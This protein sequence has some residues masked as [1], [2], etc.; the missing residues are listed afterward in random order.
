MNL[1]LHGFGAFGHATGLVLG[2]LLGMAFGFV[3]ERAGFGRAAN[4]A[5]QF[6]GHDNRVFKVMFTGI[7]TTA[8]LLG[9]LSGT[10]AVDLAMLTVPETFLGPQIVGGLLLGA[11]FI[12]AGYCPGTGVVAASSGNVDGLLTY[13]GVMVGSLL[14][15]LAWPWVEGFYGSGA[16]GAVRLDQLVGL[17]FSVVALGVAAMAIGCFVAVERLEVWMAVR[18]EKP[19]PDVAPRLRNGAFAGL[20]GV[21]VFA[22]APVVFA[23]AASPAPAPPRELGWI[24]VP[25]LAAGLV[26]DPSAYWIVDARPPAECA[27][28][29]IP[30]AMCVPA[31]DPTAAFVAALPT[32]RTLVVYDSGICAAPPEGVATWPGDVRKLGGGYTAWKAVVLTPP[33]L[34]EAPS[35]VQVR[36]YRVR[37]ALH[38]RFTG[39]AA[40]AATITVAPP[41]RAAAAPKKGGGC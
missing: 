16:M 41:R 27:G 9:L 1:P 15:G 17:P 3:L 29:R 34:L 33:A 28:D 21:G 40:P 39:V 30:G 38:G 2:V 18:R 8:V 13:V 32:T 5:A 10:G 14:F 11:G 25:T 31:D 24:D 20:A 7:A 35:L 4:L 26:E 12:V 22:L 19:A 23:P 37:S 36:D 6:Y